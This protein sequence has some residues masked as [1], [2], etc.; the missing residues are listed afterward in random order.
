[1]KQ[2]WL[3]ILGLGTLAGAV[4]IWLSRKNQVDRFSD[5]LEVQKL[6][7]QIASDLAKAEELKGQGDAARLEREKLEIDIDE[8]KRAVLVIASE[9]PTRAYEMSNAEVARAF[10]DLGL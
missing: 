9:S 3:W 4:L 6:K 5:A 1:M 8:S 7:Q 2:F 10:T